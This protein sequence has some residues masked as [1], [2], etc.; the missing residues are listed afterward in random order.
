MFIK[1]PQRNAF[2]VKTA[3]NFAQSQKNLRSC[4]AA[5]LQLLETLRGHPI[6]VTCQMSHV[7]KNG[8]SGGARRL[9]VCYQ[10]GLPRLV[11]Y[12]FLA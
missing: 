8:Q 10:W 5:Q 3:K 4:G 1:F 2:H 12:A 7:N 11:C 6:C 9:R